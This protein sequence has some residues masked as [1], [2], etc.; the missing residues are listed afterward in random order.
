MRQSFSGDMFFR[1]PLQSS[2]SARH[3]EAA[4]IT[5]SFPRFLRRRAF[6]LVEL[7]VVIAI[8]AVLI[9]LLLPALAK[10][11]EQA[12]TSQCLSNLRQF[13][14]ISEEYAADNG[15]YCFP[16]QW[17][18][19]NSGSENTVPISLGAILQPYVSYPNNNGTTTGSKMMANAASIWICPDVSEADVQARFNATFQ[20]TYACNDSV[21][22]HYEYYLYPAAPNNNPL[23]PYTEL[24]PGEP[25]YSL[26]KYSQIKRATEI[27]E[28]GD[29]SLVFYGGTPG[30]FVYS[31]P[32]V[33]ELLPKNYASKCNVNAL[34]LSYWSA[35]Q[36][37]DGSPCIPRYRH[38]N[39]NLC[40]WLFADGHA[41]SVP[42]VNPS[43][44][45]TPGG[46]ESG[47]V[48]RNIST[49]Y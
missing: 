45:P 17:D 12:R 21:H 35:N 47:L 30:Y 4:V 16:C 26:L 10:A 13:G 5:I 29:G 9:S 14:S 3:A 39:N 36:D 6:T 34:E 7:L 15:G 37:I 32:S 48:M 43:L 28:M 24:S 44:N 25:M 33:N 40:N 49:N 22:C 18:Q 27:V 11:R 41:A 31:E 46:A 38:G 1:R 20:P 2:Q 8:I 42:Y 19:Y 23:P